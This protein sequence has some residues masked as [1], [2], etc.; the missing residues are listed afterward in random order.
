MTETTTVGVRIALAGQP[1]MAALGT[2][3]HLCIARAAALGRLEPA[4]V[5][6]ILRQWGV[7]NAVT[8][9]AVETQL[10]A[11]SDWCQ[12]RWPDCPRLVEVPLEATRPGGSARDEALAQAHGP[13]LA[14]YAQALQASTGLPVLEQWLYLPVGVRML[15]VL[16]VD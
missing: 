2:A 1:D 16:R 10:K 14:A 7:A 12:Q 3:L 6:H 15:R 4:E 9:A 8:Q 13:K 5:A 11:F